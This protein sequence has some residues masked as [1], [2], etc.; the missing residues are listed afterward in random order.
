[1]GRNLATYSKA[2]IHFHVQ[3]RL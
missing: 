3:T 1:M 2:Y